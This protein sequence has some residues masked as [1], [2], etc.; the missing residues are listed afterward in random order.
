MSGDWSGLLDSEESIQSR[1]KIRSKAQL[2]KKVNAGEEE[3][4]IRC[5]YTHDPIKSNTRTSYLTYDKHQDEKFEDKVWICFSNLGFKFMSENQ[6]FKIKYSLNPNVDPQQIDVF[7]ADNDVAIVVECKSTQTFDK[8]TQFKDTILAFSAQKENIIR[9]IRTHFNNEKMS[10]GFAFI[11]NNYLISDSDKI[12]AQDVNVIMF[13]QDDIEYYN[14]LSKNIGVAA[15]YH[16]LAD[17][18]EKQDIPSIDIKIPA[19]CG[20]YNNTTIYSFLIEPAKLLPISFVAHRVKNSKS[21]ETTYQRMIKKSRIDDIRKYI[22]KEKNIFPNSI[23]INIDSN[24]LKYE[25][26]YKQNEL[27]SSGILTLPNKY[28][29]AWIIDGQHRLFSYCNTEES[30]SSFIPV[31]AFEKLSYKKQSD[32]FMDINSKQTKVDK[33]LLLEINSESHYDS[34]KPDEW[35]DALISKCILKMSKEVTNPLYMRLKSY[36]EETGGELTITSLTSAISKA[37]L[38]GQM[39]GGQLQYGFLSSPKNNIIDTK[40]NSLERGYHI[41]TGYLRFFSTI[42]DENWK[43]RGGKEKGYLCTNNGITALISVL[44]DIL[45]FVDDNPDKII[46]LNDNETI[47]RIRPYAVALAEYFKDKDKTDSD[48]IDRYRNQLGA[49]GQKQSAMD[50]E[51]VINESFSEFN[52][53]ELIRYKENTK[54]MWEE[55]TKETFPIVK[56]KII[57]TMINALKSEYNDTPLSWWKKGVPENVRVEVGSLKESDEE[58]RDY[59]FYIT[60]KTAKEIISSKDWKLFKPLFGFQSSGRKKEDQLKWLNELERIEN[61]I[62]SKSRV[63]KD[64]YDKVEEIRT[65]LDVKLSGVEMIDYENDDGSEM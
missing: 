39:S 38:F 35:L 9:E 55:R 64:D 49:H 6:N 17:I 61:L 13:T 48:I 4:W 40:D 59:E 14:S 60:L 62:N 15:K 52:S 27:I 21:T 11:T 41:L 57:K 29:S 3:K 47:N 36:T 54:K 34:D 16:V 2:I 53:P 32:M 65:F 19:I 58:E 30:N 12:C 33:N 26:T 51:V 10:V 50:M 7:A 46:S 8:K 28:K 1:K 43:R 56:D 31:V 5:G 22:E 20:T 24:S 18:F 23:I 63:T 37:G 42:A 44:G 25:E 45:K